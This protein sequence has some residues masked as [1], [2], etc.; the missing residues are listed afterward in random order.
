[1]RDGLGRDEGPPGG[2]QQGLIFGNRIW[3][4]IALDRVGALRGFVVYAN[5]G[6]LVGWM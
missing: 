1:M 4:E 2:L 5:R 6:H 3:I